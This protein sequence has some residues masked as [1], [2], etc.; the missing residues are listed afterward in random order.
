MDHAP[1]A[2]PGLRRSGACHEPGDLPPRCTLRAAK[3]ALFVQLARRSAANLAARSLQHR[4]RWREHDVVGRHADMLDRESRDGRGDPLALAG[5]GHAR[6]G[7]YDEALAAD[8]PI[9]SGKDGHAS[10]AH[11]GHVCNRSLEVGRMDVDAAADDEVFLA[12]GEDTARPRRSSR[13]RRCS[14]SRRRTGR[15]WPTGFCSSRG[16]PTAR[17]TGPDLACVR[18]ARALPHR[19]RAPRVPGAARRTTRDATR[20]DRRRE[21]ASQSRRASMRRGRRQSII[22]PRSSGGKVTP[23]TPSARPNTVNM[24]SRLKP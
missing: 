12:A 15:R 6:L 7:Q 22:G 21:L 13:G 5:I 20:S 9:G 4:S 24:A 10:L 19:R 16:S 14:A 23:S 3:R 17:E 8:A 2:A 1:R 11:A 18:Q